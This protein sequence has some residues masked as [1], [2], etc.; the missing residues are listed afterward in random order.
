MQKDDLEDS[1]S[2]K[3]L[4]KLERFTQKWEKVKPKIKFRQKV[5]SI[6]VCRNPR[7]PTLLLSQSDRTNEERRRTDVK[8]QNLYR[9]MQNFGAFFMGTCGERDQEKEG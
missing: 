7:I 1:S 8:D 5:D 2:N 6:I 3:V 9:S 4:Q